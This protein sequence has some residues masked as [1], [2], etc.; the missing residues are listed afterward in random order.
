MN[1]IS[2]LPLASGNN[3]VTFRQPT[4][5][6]AQA[7]ANSN[8]DLEEALT[9]EYLTTLLVTATGDDNPRHWTAQDR[10]LAL[11]WIYINIV[12]D[13]LITYQYPCKFCGETHTADFDMRA[14]ND[15]IVL[16]DELPVI[17]NTQT[18][19]GRK[20]TYRILPPDGRCQ[21]DTEQLRINAVEV[22]DA[23]KAGIVLLRMAHCIAF[24]DDPTDSDH[25]TVI[26]HRYTRIQSMI[27][28]EYAQLNG[29]MKAGQTALAHGIHC[30]IENGNVELITPPLL[31]ENKEDGSATRLRLDFRC[32]YFIPTLFV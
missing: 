28:Y 1:K 12:P 18:F 16:K 6:D 13:P 7:F 20:F 17:T 4:V 31:C 2:A 22:N 19:N 26:A 25:D 9:T 32:Q 3:K 23:I 29:A 15:E 24:D 5:A 30:A 21:E 27:L 14:L 8:P 10:R 11:W